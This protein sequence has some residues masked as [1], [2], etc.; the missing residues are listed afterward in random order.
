MWEEQEHQRHEADMMDWSGRPRMGP[1]QGG[2]PPP[3]MVSLVLYLVHTIT[4]CIV[5]LGYGIK[6]DSRSKTFSWI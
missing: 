3:D 6:L 2:F 1:P 5:I 4:C